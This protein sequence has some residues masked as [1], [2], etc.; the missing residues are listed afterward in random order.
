MAMKT[1]TPEDV[2]RRNKIREMSRSE[3][4][5]E[6]AKSI[7]R[8]NTK[9]RN[10]ES[11]GYDRYSGSY[12]RLRDINEKTGTHYF[13][14]SHMAKASLKERKEYLYR[15]QTYETYK[16]MTETSVKESLKKTAEKLSKGDLQ[17][18]EADIM[19]I[20]D[21]MGEWREFIMHS[22]I[23]ELMDSNEVRNIFTDNR[24]IS[25]Q[26][27]DKF[28]KE[29]EKFNTGTYRKEDFD[30]FLKSY[31]YKQGRPIAHTPEG[32]AYNPMNGRIYND[33][34]KYI[35]TSIR[36]SRSGE[37]LVRWDKDKKKST[38]TGIKIS[39][40][41]KESFYDYIFNDQRKK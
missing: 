36:L 1:R 4:K 41:S 15:L 34:L 30:V 8:L 28:M 11:S 27:F 3:V 31:D 13:S 20:N 19:R 22:N 33:E 5:A 10:L 6:I 35:K 40:F 2:V 26:D 38:D 12:A 32:V 29:L 39:D 9:M 24:E 16:G 37:N 25:R 17:L 21:Y 18:S 23:A 7:K 14:S